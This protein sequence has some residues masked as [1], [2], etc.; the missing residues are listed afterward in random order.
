MFLQAPYRVGMLWQRACVGVSRSSG[1]CFIGCVYRPA[2]VLLTETAIRSS[3]SRACRSICL[4]GRGRNAGWRG[5]YAGKAA[6]GGARRNATRPLL[7]GQAYGDVGFE[8]Q[9]G[10]SGLVQHYLTTLVLTA[11]R[12]VTMLSEAPSSCLLCF[13]PLRVTEREMHDKFYF[14]E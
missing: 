10:C 6:A 8:S 7:R 14:V 4:G 1:T 2:M 12:R 9:A 5:S 13:P 3:S 11:Q